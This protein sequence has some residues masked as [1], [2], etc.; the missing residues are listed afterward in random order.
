MSSHTQG[1]TYL[2]YIVYAAL[3]GLLLLMVAASS[4]GLG[5]RWGLA[6]ALTI[7][8]AKALLVILY[9]MH[10]RESSRVTW[11]FVAAG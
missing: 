7:A 10:V 6:V 8:V 4:W 5:A 9:F 1:S 3:L 2:Y 11:L